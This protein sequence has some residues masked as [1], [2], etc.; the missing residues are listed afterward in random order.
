MEVN[1]QVFAK[2]LEAILN[3]KGNDVSCEATTVSKNNNLILD[4]IVVN[5]KGC[6][7]SPTL[8]YQHKKSK[9]ENLKMMVDA[10]ETHKPDL[11]ISIGKILNKD[12]VLSHLVTKL[13]NYEKNKDFLEDV[14]FVSFL[15][16]ALIFM[17]DIS[18][19][20]I[21]MDKATITLHN[22]HLEY[23][24]ITLDDLKEHADP[25]YMG[26]KFISVLE[27]LRQ[28]YHM[29]NQILEESNEDDCPLYILTNKH[30]LFGAS[31][32]TDTN[33]LKNI[34]KKMNADNLYIFPSSIS[35]LI[36]LPAEGDIKND[37]RHYKSLVEEIN[38]NEV[39]AE[40]F[41]SDNVYIF[42]GNEVKIAV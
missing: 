25:C 13:I 22:S 23:L 12:Y 18:E 31:L 4:A 40:E 11:D 20:S 10:Y 7:L 15:D 26:V 9:E 16:L 14:P 5:K 39:S 19:M 6:E 42:D 37:A 21:G 17:I 29:D 34:A 24:G 8:Y 35:E 36:L 30:N 28:L 27:F 41:L 33:T 38:K 3:S 1:L 2:E 32:M